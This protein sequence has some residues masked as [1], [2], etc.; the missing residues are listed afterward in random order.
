M[1]VSAHQSS[2]QEPIIASTLAAC[3]RLHAEQQPQKTAYR[4]LRDGEVEGR[5]LTYCE[6]NRAARS[7]ASLLEQHSA[8]GDRV[9]LLFPPGLEFIIALCACFYSGRVA[10]PAYPPRPRSE[11]R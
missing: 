9:L 1:S 8:I 7:V 5:R 4:F 6:L 2:A 10:V 3:L 11:E